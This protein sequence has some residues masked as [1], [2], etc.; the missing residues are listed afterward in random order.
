MNDT[1]TYNQAAESA[2]AQVA[3]LR[4]QNKRRCMFFN[5]WL[6]HQPLVS[7]G[8]TT[9]RDIR[10]RS[11]SVSRDHADVRR[12]S[13]GEF[14]FR[15]RNSKNGVW[16]SDVGRYGKFRKVKAVTLKVGMHIRLGRVI[17]VVVDTDGMAPI[18]A[19]R[20][21]EFLRLA[22]VVYGNATG[23]ARQIGGRS[24][25]V[26]LRIINRARGSVR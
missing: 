16:V 25:A 10:I 6:K 22:A 7:I 24:Q 8:R 23:A 17:L 19:P 15:D 26:I 4:V 5:R 1:E 12:T 14:R 11:M 18:M 20:Y 21:T 9:A 2:P 13:K 3:G